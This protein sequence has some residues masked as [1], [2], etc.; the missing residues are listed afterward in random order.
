M[1][2]CRLSN[3]RCKCAA[4]ISLV[5]AAIALA[6]S[7]SA[8][9]F[10][11]SCSPLDENPAR[12]AAPGGWHKLAKSG[13]A[14]GYPVGFCSWL[15]EIGEFSGGNEYKGERPPARCIGGVDAPLTSDALA[16][17]SNTLVN[18]R[19]SGAI[20]IVRF[21]YTSGSE[22][23]T[24]PSDFGMILTHIR[25]VGA[26]LGAF[27]DVVL[28][29]ECG[30]I[31]PWGEMHSNNYRE[32][33]HIR[34]ITD[35]WLETLARETSLLVRYPKW[36]LDYADKDADDFM[37]EIAAETYYKIQP[38]QRRI[39]MFND[40]YLGTEADYGTWRTDR[41]WL[42][43]EQGIAY[44]EARRN[45]P[46][47]GELAH[48]SIEEARAVPLFDLSRH[49][50]VQEFYRTHLCYLRNIDTKRHVLAGHIET[51]KLTHDYDFEGMPDLSEWYGHDLREF[52]RTHMGYR[53]VIRNIA[54]SHD[55]VEVTVENTGFGHLLIKNKAEITAGAAKAEISM[56][57]RPLRPGKR[58]KFSIP[59]PR[60]TGPGTKL[61][62]RLYADTP[63]KQP[64]RFAND[65][66]TTDRG[67]LLEF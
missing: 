45:V 12:G 15:W 21:G 20:L 54:K 19:S 52:I 41:R 47:G 60:G 42:V 53:F 28:A 59:I 24:E 37:R 39:G 13:N 14:A 10:T 33:H 55:A 43:R 30:M 64:I 7:A 23:G 62:L 16:A 34:A 48:I 3:N 44:L 36:I 57:L 66:L 29:V 5:A 9:N 58:R 22:C 11:D 67:T 38:A 27:P 32:P 35:T 63:A 17:I 1:K 51:M 2:S 31:G 65:A 26:I 8:G 25:Q 50:I 49:N 56:D 61:F 40:G 6:C 18:A 46:Y 4:V